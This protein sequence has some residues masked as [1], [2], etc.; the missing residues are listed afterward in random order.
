MY[1]T[2]SL[3]RHGGELDTFR[4]FRGYL[5][6]CEWRAVVAHLLPGFECFLT[7]LVNIQRAQQLLELRM[8][9]ET[10]DEMDG[11][12]DYFDGVILDGTSLQSLSFCIRFFVRLFMATGISFVP[13]M[14][15]IVLLYFFKEYLQM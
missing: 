2:L 13:L 15:S 9:V 10:A 5:L 12:A 8:S 7:L 14:I 6:N 11:L 1:S 3:L 4:Q